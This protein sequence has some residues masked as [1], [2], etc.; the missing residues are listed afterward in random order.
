MISL[1]LVN[2]W[3]KKGLLL[4]FAKLNIKTRFKGT[5]LGLLWAALEP[6]LVFLL[7][8]VVFSTIK[9]R[10]GENFA[11]YLLT[12]IIIYHIFSRGTLAGLVSLQENSRIM[13]SF[14]I[15]KEFFPVSA[16][17]A[18]FLLMLVEIVVFFVLMIAF[19]FI[20]TWTVIF[21][22]LVLLLLIILIQGL[23]YILSVAFVFIKDIQP[24]WAIVI[25][26]M[27]FVSPIFW[28]IDDTEGIL[29]ILHQINPIGQ[30]IELSHKIIV[31][32]TIPS[33]SDW[34]YT[35][36]FVV[37]IF[38]AGYIIFRSFEKRIIEE[39]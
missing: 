4:H 24:I 16:T 37:A 31:F 29:A 8:W 9:I 23:S 11:I 1:P 15:K 2:L 21:Y 25:H 28:Y 14:S 36:V 33:L 18:T 17:L 39:M 26:A 32:G 12:G 6:T 38:V 3:S 22:P 10:A 27:F 30:I 7:L 13:Q 35:S 20:P 5:Y 19:Q 34:I